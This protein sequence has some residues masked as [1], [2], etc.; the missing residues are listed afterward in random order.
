MV[1]LLP[2]LI[3]GLGMGGCK[4]GGGDKA[5]AT[6]KTEWSTKPSAKPDEKGSHGKGGGSVLGLFQK[7]GQSLWKEGCTHA[8]DVMFKAAL[9]SMPDDQTRD[10]AKADMERM[11]KDASRECLEEFKKANSDAA[12]E[13]ARCMLKIT[14]QRGLEACAEML[15]ASEMKEERWEEK[16]EEKK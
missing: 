16:K 11:F 6:F 12:D 5:G 7:G 10:E 9:D 15:T 1:A 3:V 13:A 14:D 8:I 2:A 4:E